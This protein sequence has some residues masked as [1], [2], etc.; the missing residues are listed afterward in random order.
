MKWNLL[1]FYSANALQFVLFKYELRSIVGERR[2]VILAWEQRVLIS[3][4]I[5]RGLWFLHNNTL[6]KMVHGDIK[7][8]LNLT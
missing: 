7:V 2:K 8:K 4:G 3:I 6:E 1:E 5:A